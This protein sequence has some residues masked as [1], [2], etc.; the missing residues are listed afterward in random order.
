[1]SNAVFTIQQKSHYDTRLGKANFVV[2]IPK[3]KEIIQDGRFLTVR[4]IDGTKTKFEFE[5]EYKLAEKNAELQ[6]ENILE[7]INNFYK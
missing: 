5:G 3:I 2:I 1:M 6:L 4:Y 7:K